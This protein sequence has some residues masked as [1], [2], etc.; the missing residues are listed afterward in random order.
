[1][2]EEY[3]KSGYG[4]VLPWGGVVYPPYAPPV[5]EAGNLSDLGI[6][7]ATLGAIAE[8]DNAIGGFCMTRL[9]ADHPS[10]STTLQVESA[11]DW[12]SIGH[13]GIGGV[14]YGYT[15]T[16]LTTITGVSHVAG[17]IEVAGTAM[18][19][20]KDSAVIDVSMQRSAMDRLRRALLVDYAEA[21][22]LVTI[23][24]NL[25]V[26]YRPI[27]G[28]D[29]RYRGVIKAMAYCPKGTIQGIELAM[30]A[31]VGAGNYTIY[32]DLITHPNTV[33]IRLNESV[34]TGTAS[35]G[36]AYLTGPAWDALSG[37]SD[38]L[39]LAS[40][41][42]T[43]QGVTLKD[44]GE[45]FDF[46]N[47]K[48]SEVTYPYWEG[49]T[50]AA[51][52]TYEGSVLEG[53]GVIQFAGL[54]TKLKS[55]APSGTVYYRM[56]APHGARIIP[57]SHVEASAVLQIPTGSTLTAGK[58]LQASIDIFDG[59]FRV[60]AG[61]ENTRAFGLFA[62]EAGG[63]LGNTVTLNL[64]Q[65]YDISIKKFGEDHV[66]LWIDG[67][68][69][70][71]QLYSAFTTPTT[72]HQLEF[73]IAGTPSA[74]MEVW[75]KEVNLNIK[76][77]RDYWSSR[78][79]AT[80]TVATANPKQF[81]LFGSSYTFLPSDAGKGFEIK[82]SSA[83][84]PSNNGKFVIDSYVSGTT[85]TLKG[86]QKNGATLSGTNRITLDD[87]NGFTYPDDIGK[88]IVITGSALENNGIYVIT[89]LLQPGDEPL[90]FATQRTEK[91]NICEVSGTLVN[92]IGLDYRIDPVFSDETGLDWV[93]SDS[94]SIAGTSITLRQPLW[95]NGLVMEVGYSDV[96]TGQILKDT[97]LGN[98]VVS[99]GPPV[100]YEYYPLYL[101][102]TVGALSSYIDTITVAGVIPELLAG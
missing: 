95:E 99:D 38:T 101:S 86:A 13:V 58:L 37:S 91:T 2:S 94:S 22:D 16:T 33:F 59:A 46:R 75:F 5:S 30:T 9:T 29:E 57:E 67:E 90:A 77:T 44:M 14:L 70:D 12:P 102:D 93:Q 85:I 43:V 98:V 71:S 78:E 54:Y 60:R 83:S 20:K 17:G 55:N 32:E 7:E 80:G 45:A 63:H 76:S 100:L 96:L 47:D 31:L 6:L 10:G 35:A 1:M 41:P 51:A 82:G 64:D 36:K 21:E 65:F 4:I 18:D 92:E 39:A 11:L 48:P 24:R 87:P 52:F 61:I 27:F 25:G 68:L 40:E 42:T 49:Q 19:H 62:T 26:L 50:P 34:V 74:N 73:G 3:G 8:E 81:V 66:E 69:V 72:D 84:N 28:D 15:G 79:S 56:D 89:A 88:E 23:G 97:S 53:T